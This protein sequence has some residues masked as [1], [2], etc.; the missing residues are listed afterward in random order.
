MKISPEMR[1][2]IDRAVAEG[3]VTVCPPA[4]PKQKLRVAQPVRARG[5]YPQG[6]G[7]DS[8][9][10]G[11]MPQPPRSGAPV[12]G[13]AAALPDSGAAAPSVIASMS[14][15]DLIELRARIGAAIA[16]R[17]AGR[18]SRAEDKHNRKLLRR[19]AA[20]I[21]TDY[22]NRRN[23]F[24]TPALGS[25]KTDV[26]GLDRSRFPDMVRHASPDQIVLKGGEN[27]VKL[28][29]AVLVGDLKGA[30][31]VSLALEERVTCPR[32]CDLWS[33]CYTNSM[34]R[35]I[36]YHWNEATRDKIR[37]ELSVL[38]K[39][40][41]KVLVRLHLSGD[42]PDP[43]AVKFWQNL[44]NDNPGLHIFGFTAWEE[45][46]PTGAAISNLRQRHPQRFAVRTSGRTGK[47]GSF[48]IPARI[49]TPMI[50]DAVVCPEQ[51]DANAGFPHRTHCGSCGLCWKSDP[52]GA[53]RPVVFM[54]H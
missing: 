44:L 6:S 47:W 32:S 40:Y 37:Q 52:K 26:P 34:P 54:G 17:Q 19:A 38:L 31:L 7:F 10:A 22:D 41:R 28:G 43:D 36:R 45:D 18:M 13:I 3:R 51:R 1:E 20:K 24:G 2:A 48:V 27:E 5:F 4:A 25:F 53:G 35:L 29:G 46:T 15:Q 42:F 39:D 11:Q 21:A 30:R 33:K 16:A 9:R 50:G 49:D 14:Y 12:M 23:I 8:S